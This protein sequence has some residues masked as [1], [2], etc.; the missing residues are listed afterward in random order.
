MLAI[1][2]ASISVQVLN[3]SFN[4][5]SLQCS[6]KFTAISYVHNPWL[7]SPFLLREYIHPQMVSQKRWFANCVSKVH[8]RGLPKERLLYSLLIITMASEQVTSLLPCSLATSQHCRVHDIEFAT[9]LGLYTCIYRHNY[10]DGLW[11][12]SHNVCSLKAWHSWLVRTMIQSNRVNLHSL[13]SLSVTHCLDCSHRRYYP[14]PQPHCWH[15]WDDSTGRTGE[16]HGD[17]G[18]RWRRW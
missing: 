12:W 3:F 1:I 16:F 13:Y 17:W 8:R 11:F 2:T 15:W 9:T 5:Q 6:F 4:F 18:G 10:N 14:H 7:Y